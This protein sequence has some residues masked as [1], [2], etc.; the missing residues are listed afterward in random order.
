M[1][2]AADI[3]ELSQVELKLLMKRATNA[4]VVYLSSLNLFAPTCFGLQWTI[5]RVLNIKEYSKLQRVHCSK[6]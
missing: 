5:I 4:A 2:C 3:R 1:F 6:T